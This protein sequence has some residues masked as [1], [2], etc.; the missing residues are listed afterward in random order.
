MRRVYLGP[1]EEKVRKK[2]RLWSDEEVMKKL[3]R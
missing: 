3:R 2:L 1:D